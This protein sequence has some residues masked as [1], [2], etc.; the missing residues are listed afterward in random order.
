MRPRPRRAAFRLAIMLAF[1]L[2]CGAC[3]SPLDPASAAMSERARP[4]DS[5]AAR[6]ST[7]ARERGA[8]LVIAAMGY[9]GVP[10]RSGGNGGDGGFDC[11]GFTRHI[12]A[13]GLGLMLP[14]S[15]DEQAAAR[16]LVQVDKG[17]LQPGD[18][19]FFNT[20]KRTYSHVGIYIGEGRFVHAPKTGSEV[21][22]ESM[23]H[24]YWAERYTGGRRASLPEGP[25]AV[26][27]TLPPTTN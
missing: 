2:L 13:L 18:L 19:V 27:T 6:D 5:A 10:Y 22:I 1:S 21:R 17:D 16:G 3:A 15:A 12:Y 14:R 26:R 8:S 23:R 25:V 24:A 9:V 4:A 11:S 7:A 20:L